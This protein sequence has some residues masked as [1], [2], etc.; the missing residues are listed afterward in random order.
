MN[1]ANGYQHHDVKHFYE[2]VRAHNKGSAVINRP[3]LFIILYL[4]L[5]CVLPEPLCCLVSEPNV[6]SIK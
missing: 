5:C 6:L 1:H 4:S 3:L 2:L